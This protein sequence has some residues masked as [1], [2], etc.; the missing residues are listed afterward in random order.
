MEKEIDIIVNAAILWTMTQ[1]NKRLSDDKLVANLNAIEH[2]C[3]KQIME[4]IKKYEVADTPT[5]G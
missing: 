3:V 4:V 5:A 1:M 2:D